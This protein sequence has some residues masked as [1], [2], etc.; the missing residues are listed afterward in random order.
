MLVTGS[1]KAVSA[2]DLDKRLEGEIESLYS[3]FK[4]RDITSGIIFLACL[5]L[6][7]NA[8]RDYEEMPEGGQTV[9]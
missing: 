3:H 4:G 8:M 6:V 1:M 7:M 5:E 2:H 9:N